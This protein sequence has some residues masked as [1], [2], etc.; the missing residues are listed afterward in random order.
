MPPIM[1][2]VAAPMAAPLPASPP[3]APP[4]AP[5]AAPRAAP[6]NRAA[7]WRR[8]LRRH[9]LGHARVDAGLLGRPHLA[10]GRILR[11]LLGALALLR[12]DKR[13]PPRRAR[14]EQQRARRHPRLHE[15]G[16]CRYHPRSSCSECYRDCRGPADT[17][18][19]WRRHQ[20]MERPVRIPATT[21]CRRDQHGDGDRPRDAEGRDMD[22]LAP[23]GRAHETRRITL[24]KVPMPI[25]IRRLNRRVGSATEP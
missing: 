6:A 8:R 15:Y 4:T 13:L 1:A 16:S 7:R 24:R 11:L 22:A 25:G 5:T 18:P 20:T 10:L 17:M 21:R 19:A 14:G 9:L 23:G 2:P 3:M 12:V